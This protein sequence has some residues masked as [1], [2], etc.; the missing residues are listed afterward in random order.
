MEVEFLEA[1]AAA[2]APDPEP[3][4]PTVERQEPSVE[5][6]EPSVASIPELFDQVKKFEFW[7]KAILPSTTRKI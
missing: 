4:E 5:H 6:Q 7:A 1:E 2:A 3:T